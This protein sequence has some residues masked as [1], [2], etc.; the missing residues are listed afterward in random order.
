MTED[1]RRMNFMLALQRSGL[2]LTP[3]ELGFLD[4]ATAQ[5]GFSHKQRRWIDSLRVKYEEKLDQNQ[6]A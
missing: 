4:S 1:D 6:R 3:S 5:L 2:K